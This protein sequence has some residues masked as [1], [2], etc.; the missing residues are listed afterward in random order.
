MTE[1]DLDL[2]V[3]TRR[4]FWSMGY[5]TRLDVPLRGFSPIGEF[6]GRSRSPETFTDLDVLGFSVVGG[7]RLS[8]EIAD[9]KTSRKESTARM[10]WLRGIADL[11]GA[12]HAY[13]V[14]QHEVTDAARQLSA[15][16][17]I[18]VLPGIELKN[19]QDQ[20]GPPIPDGEHPLA[21]LFDTSAA[22]S[23]LAAFTK[24]DRQLNDLIE[25][26]NFDYW[27]YEDYRNLVQMVA[28][29]SGANRVLDPRN[30]IHV[31]LLIDLS[32]LYLLT[33]IRA[34]THIRGAFLSNLDRGLQEYMFGGVLNLQEKQEVARLLVTLRPSK[35]SKKLDH[36][37]PYYKLLLDLVFR[38]LRRPG[39]MQTA[40]RY[41]EVA[42]AFAAAKA[43]VTLP[44]AFA[45][46]SSFDAV[47][48][49][50]V[51]DVCGFLV[52]TAQLDSGF[53]W[54]V[55]AY[56]LAEEPPASTHHAA[57]S[58]S[59]PTPGIQRQATGGEPSQ[60]EQLS[61]DHTDSKEDKKSAEEPPSNSSS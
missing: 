51:A 4:L 49:K 58:N 38:L 26:R 44:D 3:A 59:S 15:R 7:H 47:A 2:K 42:T 1:L 13:L 53:R 18:T 28:H 43:R 45:F 19:I 14:R 54:R 60:L 12:D 34:I 29:L 55:R 11:F 17:G 24:L 39:Q 25:Y 10:F 21:M 22:A 16:L 40:L 23:H 32:W 52:A 31:A 46:S 57:A 35:S 30:P 37:P 61:L 56:L 6:S 50:L 8:A 41:A 48:A 5:S 27:V 36:L 33:L 9:C 20:Y